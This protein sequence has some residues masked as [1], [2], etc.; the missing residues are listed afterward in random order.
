MDSEGLVG[1]DNVHLE[2]KVHGAAASQ[3][4][5]VTDAADRKEDTHEMFS[6]V[7]EGS[8]P[9]GKSSG[10]TGSQNTHTHTSVRAALLGGRSEEG[11]AGHR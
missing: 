9:T 10:R 8:E 1:L 4:N 7:R 2:L 3:R 11:R 6:V 5:G